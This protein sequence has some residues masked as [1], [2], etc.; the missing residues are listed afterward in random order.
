MGNATNHE[1][2]TLVEQHADLEWSRSVLQGRGDKQDS[3]GAAINMLRRLAHY[4][5]T[6][7]IRRSAVTT[8]SARHT[9]A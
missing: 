7:L 8:L 5:C 4:G 6:D 9:M 3:Q 2:E 1:V